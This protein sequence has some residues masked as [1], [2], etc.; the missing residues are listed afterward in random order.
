MLGH[1]G[2]DLIGRYGVVPLPPNGGP[3]VILSRVRYTAMAAGTGTWSNGTTRS[4]TALLPLSRH[5]PPHRHPITAARRRA[6]RHRPLRPGPPLP[7]VRPP[8]PNTS[9]PPSPHSTS[10]ASGAATGVAIVLPNGPEM[11]SA[12]VAIA[13]GA[14]T[15]PL[16]PAY[17]EPEFEFYLSDLGAK[18][19]V[20]AEGDDS[21]AR[22]AARRPRNPGP[23]DRSRPRRRRGATFHFASEPA[24]A[25]AAHP[26]MATPRRPSPSS[27]TPPA[28]PRAPKLVPLLHR[29][30]CATAEHIR[31]TLRLE[32]ADRC[33]NVMPLFHIHGLMACVL[34]TLH[35]GGSV[36][37][38]PGFNALQSL[39]M[40]RRRRPD[41]VFRRPDNA[42]GDP[43]PRRPQ[44]RHH[45]PA[46]TPFH[47]LLVGR[48]ADPRDG[49]TG[50]PLRSSRRRGIRHDRGPRT[51]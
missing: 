47:P 10:A 15:A 19:L 1:P 28:P 31:R 3:H 7:H 34:S 48:A 2:P 49:R 5:A 40:A 51:R 42:P 27:C 11:A 33:L 8:A 44:P 32:S 6:R 22:T 29:N 25:P 39:R 17:R 37:C 4:P 36:H 46:A 20:V 16:N 18:A 35:A 21:P 45:R 50:R 43:G 12:F 24:S 13:A 30:V 14:A 23:G 38:A 26:G 41:L 9:K